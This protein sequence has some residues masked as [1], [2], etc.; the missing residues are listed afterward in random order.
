MMNDAF[1]VYIESP[2]TPITGERRRRCLQT[3]RHMTLLASRP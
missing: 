3:D 2:W 1:S